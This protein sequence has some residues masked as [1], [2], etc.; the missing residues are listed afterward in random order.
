MD[1]PTIVIGL[2][3]PGLRYRPTRHNIGFRVIDELAE[4]G[5]LALASD[6]ELRRYAWTA[7]DPERDLVLA[8]PRT[9]MNRS[10]RAAAAL[11]R[12]FA[13]TPEKLLVIY[14]DADLALGKVRLRH[15]GGA[16]GHNGIRSIAEVLG[17][18]AFRRVR[19]GVSGKGRE[20]RELADYVLEPF[21]EDEEPIVEALVTLGADAVG[22][23]LDDGMELAMNRFNGRVAAPETD[24]SMGGSADPSAVATESEEG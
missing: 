6:G 14:D 11:C 13:V 17:T 16:G 4:R 21:A 19:L 24:A 3:N 15:E 9:Y 22:A 23:V 8:K 5:R 2:G 7:T 20:E 10:G 12:S 1:G 18:G